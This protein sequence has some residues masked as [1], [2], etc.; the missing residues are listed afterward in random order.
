MLNIYYGDMPEA[1]YNTP[2]YF[3][4]GY[5]KKW[6]EDELVQQ[7]VKA[8]DR[9]TVLSNGAVDSPVFGVIPPT[10]LSGGVKTLILIYK[11][12]DKIFNASNCGDDCARWLLKIGKQQDVTINLRHMINFGKRKFTVRLLNTDQVVHSMKELVW[13]AGD[14]V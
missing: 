10:Q 9:S 12:P 11:E 3:K 6:F 2:V 1:I 8:V 5:D 13:I 4:N 14:Y 7:M